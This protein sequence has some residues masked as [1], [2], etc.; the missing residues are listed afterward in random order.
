VGIGAA[1]T[2]R[3]LRA[4]VKRTAVVNRMLKK[5]RCWGW[6]WARLGWGWLVLCGWVDRWVDGGRKEWR[7]SARREECRVRRLARVEKVEGLKRESRGEKVLVDGER[8]KARFKR[9]L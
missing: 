6:G 7:S 5:E 1:E 8:E 9:F 2:E 4:A 3:V